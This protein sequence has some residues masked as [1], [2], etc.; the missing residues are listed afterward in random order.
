MTAS[1]ETAKRKRGRPRATPDSK[2][3]PGPNSTAAEAGSVGPETLVDLALVL[4]TEQPPSEITRASLARHANV[5]PGLIRYYFKNRDSLMRTVAESLTKALQRRATSATAKTKLSAPDHISTRVRALL[6]F[7][8]DNPFYHRLMM[9]DMAQSESGE[10]RA[11]FDEVSSSAIA[12]YAGYLA[13]GVDDGTL[14]D[15]EPAYLYMAIIGLC[16]FYVTASPVILRDFDKKSRKDA[17]SKYA[18]FICDILMNGLR[19]R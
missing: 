4:L 15:V 2:A 7:K 16:D 12:R 18:E 8:L 14:R 13:E 5:D 1:S 17:D 19:P 3:S 11:L 10:S 6:A 9:E